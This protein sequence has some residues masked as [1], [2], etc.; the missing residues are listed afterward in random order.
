MLIKRYLLLV[1]V[2]VAMGLATV[3]WKTRT[4]A[5]GYEAARLERQV[6]R[7][8]EEELL[9]QS[10]LACLT[11]PAAVADKAKGLGL[12]SSTDAPRKALAG[13]RTGRGGDRCVA[14]TGQQ[15]RPGGN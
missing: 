7:A 12:Q 15:P 4:L 8:T 2:L 6:A 3:W 14:M 10:R 13:R 1:G 9:E 11:A 5:L